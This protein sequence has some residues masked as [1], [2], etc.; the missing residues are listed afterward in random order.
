M[1]TMPSAEHYSSSAGLTRCL[2][3]LGKVITACLH[4]HQ[5]KNYDI[6]SVNFA[7]LNSCITAAMFRHIMVGTVI[8][9]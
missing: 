3:S 2:R 4:Q 6:R 9:L 1:R 7:K 8:K 5:I